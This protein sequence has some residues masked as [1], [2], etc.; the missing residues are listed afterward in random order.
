M[1]YNPVIVYLSASILA[2]CAGSA[3]HEIVSSNQ[4]GDGALSCIEI[5]NEIVK[6]QVII[7]GVNKDKD[8]NA[9][10]KSYHCGGAKVYHFA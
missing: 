3:T 9:R 8:V 6:T 5:N 2:A 1:K 7:D 10:A 4:S